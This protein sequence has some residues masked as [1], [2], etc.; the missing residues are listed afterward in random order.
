MCSGEPTVVSDAALRLV[1]L[2]GVF[3]KIQSKR[4]SPDRGN[5]P[6]SVGAN[7]KLRAAT[8]WQQ[9]VSLDDSLAATLG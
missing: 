9:A 3:A 8:S 7:D 4:A 1:E 2:S 6:W 5:V